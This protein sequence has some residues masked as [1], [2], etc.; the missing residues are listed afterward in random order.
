M[1]ALKSIVGILFI[2]LAGAAAA[3]PADWDPFLE[4]TKDF[5]PISRPAGPFE[6]VVAERI[7]EKCVRVPPP[8]LPSI[9]QSLDN[10][11]P[12]AGNVTLQ[13]VPCE[14]IPGTISALKNKIA[15]YNE[16]IKQVD[17]AITSGQEA[18]KIVGDTIQT[19][20]PLSQ[21]QG[22]AC[23]NVYRPYIIA[24]EKK[25]K[26]LRAACRQ[27]SLPNRQ[28]C[29]DD[30]EADT[31]ITSGVWPLYLKM[32]AKCDPFE[33]TSS[34]LQDAKAKE[35]KYKSDLIKLRNERQ[36]LVADKARTQRQINQ[37]RQEG[38][39]CPKPWD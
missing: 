14:K 9:N 12:T 35:A 30:V 27:V 34:R 38:N 29:M 24:F 39:D 10:L 25:A 3:L 7:I 26:Q 15:K 5:V 22:A 37:L 32:R 13:D 23:S 33:A 6:T 4:C 20:T 28:D 16:A 18:Q 19:L 36:Q 31:N 8:D 11:R 2:S 17:A 21:S 1:K